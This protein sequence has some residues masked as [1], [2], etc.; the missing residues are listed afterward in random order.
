VLK[1]VM[2]F[3]LLLVLLIFAAA[4]VNMREVSALVLQCDGKGNIVRIAP[5]ADA[6]SCTQCA[7][8]TRG[9]DSAPL[10]SDAK[11]I[12]HQAQ[13]AS[14]TISLRATHA[15]LI[16]NKSSDN[17]DRQ[18]IT[19]IISLA[20]EADVDPYAVLALVILENPPVLKSKKTGNDK[21]FQYDSLYGAIPVD[22]VAALDIL[23]CEIAKPD[24]K[25][26]ATFDS[27]KVAA[28]ND[29]QNAQKKYI[30]RYYELIGS[31]DVTKYLV[32]VAR[33]QKGH[34]PPPSATTS[35]AKE[36]VNSQS[37][38]KA[39]DERKW[40]IISSMNLNSHDQG[41]LQCVINAAGDCRGIISS[42][43]TTPTFDFTDSHPAEVRSS[44][45]YCENSEG[46]LGVGWNSRFSSDGTG[47]CCVN[48]NADSKT[49]ED[50]LNRLIRNRI[51]LEFFKRNIEKGIA[52]GETVEHALQRYNGL[53]CFGCSEAQSLQDT[54]LGLID[55]STRPVYGAEVGDVM[56]NMLMQNSD[57][58]SMVTR[59]QART[60]KPLRSLFC[61]NHPPEIVAID[62]SKFLNLQTEYLLKG[63][64]GDYTLAF[65][66]PNGRFKLKKPMS[67][68][69]KSTYNEVE[70][71][72]AKICSKNFSY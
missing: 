5:D 64:S 38:A 17:Y 2:S 32:D 40:Q 42:Q 22:N 52:S 70:T 59:E 1:Y 20:L 3:K 26:L 54:C 55:M 6:S 39:N 14:G 44:K 31:P 53:G 15:S 56:L 35:D 27:K 24:I 41:L 18:A 67:A 60:G 47:K 72:R 51:G 49:S 57:L 9:D 62:D 45:R 23:G 48:V 58:I 66:E 16:S 43:K 8:S 46:F 63:T 13:L 65:K 34:R 12:K 30:R 71:S 61:I 19:E 7:L 10:K 25:M 11:T 69:E 50:E 21:L 29:I 37:I 68:E 4:F 33:A 28:F 36:F